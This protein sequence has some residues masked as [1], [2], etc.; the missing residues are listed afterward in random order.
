MDNIFSEKKNKSKKIYFRQF[1][2][3]KYAAFVS[4]HKV[5]HISSLAVVCTLIISPVRG[6][7]QN[8]SSSVSK[9]IELEEVEIVGQKSPVL[10]EDSPRMVAVVGPKELASAP[11]QS[12][13]DLL[14]YTSNI[15]IRQRGKNSIQ[16]DV[17]IRGGSF[18]QNLILFN[19][20][21]ISD[22]QTGH[23]SL[24]LPVET[25]AINRIE[26]LNGPAAR[27]HG[28]NAF[29]GAINFVTRPLNY[30]S[31]NIHIAGGSYTYG[32]A[33]VTINL[34]SKKYRQLL[35]Y[36]YAQSGGYTQN[37]DFK[38]Q[39]F[40]YQG[41]YLNNEGILDLQLGY[42]TREFGANGYYTPKYP[43]QY[44]KNSLFLFSLG[45][46]TGKRLV[47]QPKVYWRR[48][49]DRFELFREDKDWYRLED[50]MA[51]SNNLS[52]TSFDTVSWYSGHN[53]H[54]NDVVGAQINIST[55]TSLGTSTIGWH[56]RSE[57]II[58]TN[59]G[60]DKGIVVPVRAYPGVN[61]TKGDNR[62][63]FDMHAEQTFE[64]GP[65]II[66]A[67]FLLNWNT[68]SPD[69]LSILPGIDLSYHI[70]ENLHITGSYNYTLGLPT[71]TDLTYEDPNNIGNNEL[72]P[73]TQQSVEAGLK[74][75]H[76]KGMTSMAV[77]YNAGE[78]VID[79][80]WFQDISRYKPVNVD[81][82]NCGGFELSSMQSF[83][84]HRNIP[85][86]IR[87]LRVA[88]AYLKMNKEIPGDVSKYFNLRHR[89]SAMIQQEIISGLDLSWNVNFNER[90]GSFLTY[91]FENNEYVTNS[92]SPY[93]LVD[94]RLSYTWQWITGY[95]E[96]TN[97]LNTEYIDIGSISQP[98]RWISLGI[99]I[100]LQ[101]FK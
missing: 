53:H 50:S 80:V 9:V 5:V 71:F 38:K 44:E 92:Y 7:T 24:H 72:K 6:S 61:Y 78:D 31:L 19:G 76:G 11:S 84:L 95:A 89:F 65:A 25:E 94:V 85:F 97:L 35:H 8:D 83:S 55:H 33:S 48:H 41:Q 14:R 51:I 37:T 40:F 32:K 60:Y 46:K 91:N 36:N 47:I 100:N 20:L 96:A 86:S 22:P 23:L 81:E 79:W 27:V 49:R 57:N 62:T 101:N 18:D 52:Q 30:N 82:Y 26:V 64:L 10:F 43:D 66:T 39:G 16:S 98:G 56:I 1:S 21:N 88:Y 42:N 77:F 99:Q 34:A 73:Y 12:I 75:M 69:K 3:K 29:S 90:E 54:I 28:V 45:Y 67:G 93:W 58:S 87:S 17:S 68:Y 70:F 15:D 13:S 74:F 63:N 59:I 4:M 2:R